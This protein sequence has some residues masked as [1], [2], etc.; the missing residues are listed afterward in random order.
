ME[1][2]LASKGTRRR[3]GGKV[4]VCF[5]LGAACMDNPSRAAIAVGC[6]AI[7]LTGCGASGKDS[8]APPE[9]PAEQTPRAATAQRTEQ[10]SAPTLS[11]PTAEVILNDAQGEQVATAVLREQADGVMIT[12]DGAELPNGKRGFH[13]H[14]IGRCVGPSFESAGEHLNLTKRQHGFDNPYG[15]HLG[16]LPNLLIRG[17]LAATQSLLARG[18]TL[19]PG[20]HSLRGRALVV[21]AGAD[22]YRTNPAGGSGARIA[23]GVIPFA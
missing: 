23:C 12:V 20:P 10:P 1:A 9:A 8:A 2:K 4:L 21:H 5:L 22:D 11:K 13:I 7:L 6:L 17:E 15:P 18:V 14:R 16:D 19:A 3:D